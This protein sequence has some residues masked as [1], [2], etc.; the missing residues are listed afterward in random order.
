LGYGLPEAREFAE[1]LVSSGTEGSEGQRERAVAAAHVLVLSAEDSGWAVIWP[2][3]QKDDEFGSAVVDAIS[4]GARHSGLPQWHLTE[5]QVAD[6]YIWLARRYPRP[7]Y[8]VDFGNGMITYGRKE[9]IAEWRDDVM[10]DLRNRGTFEAC[11]QIERVVAELPELRETLKWTLYQARAEARRHTWLPPKP[12]HVLALAA[13][14][15]ARLVQNGDDLLKVLVE[16]LGRLGE[17]LQGE[18]PMAPALWN[19]ANGSYT[20]KDEDWFSD[21]VKS[22]LQEDLRGRGV[23]LN[24]EVVIRKGEGEG[25]GERTDLHVDAFVAGSNSDIPNQ[26]LAIIEAKG[27]WN[28][29]LDTAMEEQLVD[30]YLNDNPVCRHGLYLVGWFNCRQWDETDWRKKRAPKYSIGEARERF[31]EQAR[32][33]S[34]EDLRVRAV[35]VDAALR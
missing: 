24:R 25:R 33:L 32:M 31:A 2:A 6:L 20:P 17:K 28:R 7:E 1:S 8:S 12:Q 23:V 35:V 16:S 3:M 26:V 19:Q 9:N 34:D 30:R 13:R 27:C 11:R 15:T 5:H 14:P 22:H 29:E 21:Y 10:Q 4:A 18:T